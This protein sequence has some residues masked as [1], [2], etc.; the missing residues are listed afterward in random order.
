MDAED[1]R[2]AT[3]PLM[4]ALLITS[5]MD[6]EMENMRVSLLLMTVVLVESL[7]RAIMIGHATGW[8]MV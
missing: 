6:A 4:V 1:I 5:T 7:M 2:R 8:H 3:M